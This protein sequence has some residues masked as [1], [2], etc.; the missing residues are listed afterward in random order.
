MPATDTPVIAPAELAAARPDAV[1]LFLSDLLA[2][3]RVMPPEVEAAGECWVDVEALGPTAQPVNAFRFSDPSALL[4]Y[5]FNPAGDTGPRIANFGGTCGSVLSSV[6][7]A[8]L[9]PA[10]PRATQSRRATV[11]PAGVRVLRRRAATHLR[12]IPTEFESK[13]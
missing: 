5:G 10:R 12:G 8:R 2:E 9:A 11:P 13:P 3:M 1:V 6:N 7:T 4:Q